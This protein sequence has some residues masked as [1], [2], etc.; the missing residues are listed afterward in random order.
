MDEVSILL[1]HTAAA[2]VLDSWCYIT[3]QWSGLQGS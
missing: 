1:R 2:V 3:T